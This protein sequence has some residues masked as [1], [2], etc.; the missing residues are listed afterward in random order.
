MFSADE[1][2]SSLTMHQLVREAGDDNEAALAE[3]QDRLQNK[4]YNSSDLRQGEN[5]NDLFSILKMDNK[6]L[7]YIA[8]ECGNAHA[9][10][11]LLNDH[12]PEYMYHGTGFYKEKMPLHSVIN[13]EYLR[14]CKEG[15]QRKEKYEEIV[16]LLVNKSIA[17]QRNSPDGLLGYAGETYENFFGRI[18]LE[19]T[20]ELLSSLFKKISPNELLKAEIQSRFCDYEAVLRLLKL[21]IKNDIPLDLNELLMVVL[22]R[23]FI[24][25]EN[26]SILLKFTMENNISLDLNKELME[27]AL[28][29][30]A[31][32]VGDYHL[33]RYLHEQYGV[34]ITQ[35]LLKAVVIECQSD[36]TDYKNYTDLIRYMILTIEIECPLELLQRVEKDK[37]ELLPYLRN[38]IDIQIEMLF[39]RNEELI[40]RAL[41]SKG[42][43]S[44]PANLTIQERPVED[45]IRTVLFNQLST[46]Y[47]YLKEN[48]DNPF[49]KKYCEFFERMDISY[50]DGDSGVL[51]T[52]I[53]ITHDELNILKSIIVDSY[54]VTDQLVFAQLPSDSPWD[55]E[56]NGTR[57]E[58][59][60]GSAFFRPAP[61]AEEDRGKGKE[62]AEEAA[63]AS[64]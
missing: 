6:T 11:M 55:L 20:D 43:D 45:G 41:Q 1:E 30:V 38:A 18:M 61:P 35:D 63:R 2:L 14:A 59:G 12:T 29:I 62:S 22:Q 37:P 33:V 13:T 58:I 24:S 21:A 44:K 27:K 26:I 50:Q 32:E 52:R 51:S 31:R 53:F 9:L 7:V 25:T 47:N 16:F 39:F 17:I 57:A 60:G 46:I 10:R 36:Y 4:R 23:S 42:L 8:A 48:R 19:G 49:V 5:D 28:Y 40:I 34:A 3:L 56:R 15:G 54:Q 64:F